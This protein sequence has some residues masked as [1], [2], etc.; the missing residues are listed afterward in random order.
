MRQNTSLKDRRRVVRSVLDRVRVRHNVAVADLGPAE[1]R[2][3]AELAFACVG[4]NQGLLEKVL[5]A[6][7]QQ[8][9]STVEAEVV[10]TNVEIR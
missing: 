1:D 7:L 8:V 4:S 2:Q 5:A 9:E 10:D 6:V 3:R